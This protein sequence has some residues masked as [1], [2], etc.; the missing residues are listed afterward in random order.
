MTCPICKNKKKELLKQY[1]G[2]HPLFSKLKIATC[3]QCELTYAYPMPS[4]GKLESYYQGYWNGNVATINPSTLRY[5]L[6]QS[7]NR[8][9]YLKSKIRIV[10]GIKVLDIGAG[11]GMFLDAVN[12]E[13][14]DIDYIAIEP[15]LIQSKILLKKNKVKKV[16]SKIEDLEK[17][18]KFD[19]IILS[20]VLEHVSQP[21]MF[22]QQISSMLKPNGFL[23]IEVPNQDHLFKKE[24]EPHILFFSETSLERLLKP[25]GDILNIECFGATPKEEREYLSTENISVSTKFKEG[26]KSLMIRVIA[27]SPR[28]LIKT[29]KMAELNPKG[30]WIRATIKGSLPIE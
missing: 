23:Y 22:I 8:V 5:Y 20:H 11:S 26:L 16:F 13:G 2:R 27:K 12:H 18:L 28:L 6:A 7:I 21:N 14:F 1:E 24:F 10:N 3:A 30:M 4:S 17:G 9:S 25:Y 19:L 29:L 15:D